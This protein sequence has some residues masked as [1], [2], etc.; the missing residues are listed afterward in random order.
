MK[1]TQ[2]FNKINILSQITTDLEISSLAMSLEQV[3]NDSLFFCINGTKEDGHNLAQT[4]IKLGAKALVVERLLELKVPQILVQNTR[5]V[6]GPCANNFYHNPLQNITL[7]GITGTNG[8]TTSTYMIQ[9]I[10]LTAGRRVGVIGTLG[11]VIDKK[12][13]PATLTTPDPLEL[14]QIFR[15]MADEN[16]DTIIMEVSAHA[17][18]LNKIEGILFDIGVLTNVTQDH[19]DFFKTFQNYSQTKQEFISPKFCKIGVVNVDDPVGLDLFLNNPNPEFRIKT[20]GLKNPADCFA[21]KINYSLNGTTY[22]LN[23]EDNLNA[24]NTRLIGEFNVYNAMGASSVC[25]LL[26][27]DDDIIKNGLSTTKFVDGRF[28]VLTLKNGAYAIID[29]AHTPDGLENVL[30][31]V[32]QI[33][34]KKIYSLFGCGGNRDKTKRPIMGEIS[35]KLADF[36]IITS[37]NPRFENPESILEDIETGIKKVTTNYTCITNREKAINYVLRMLKKG[38]CVVIAGKGAENY[39]DIQGKKI[40]YSDKETIYNEYEKI[41]KEAI[42]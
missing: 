7:I 2:I 40:P 36:T 6:I 17:I 8:K 37:D 15:Q 24:I 33:C 18:A 28:N 1:L 27:I 5:K 12:S 10:L 32:R 16:I 35:G 38:D 42:K 41:N 9:N 26:D 22:F 39:L 30:S 23:D 21:T 3:K 13:Y 31:S 29:Y 34:N 14:F 19:L 20:F 11:I 25:S 4:A